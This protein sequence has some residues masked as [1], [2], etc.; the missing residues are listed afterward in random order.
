MVD[1]AEENPNYDAREA[2]HLSDSNEENRSADSDQVDMMQK[3]GPLD[4]DD[5]DN[6]KVGD[7]L[8][9]THDGKVTKEILTVGSG[10]RLNRSYKTWIE[11]KAYFF[12]DHLIFDQS[13]PEP[14][15]LCLGDNSWP[16]G[17]QTGV[18]K[19]RKGEV[20]K[21]RIKKIHGFGRPLR[22]DELRFPKGYEQEGS[23]L[24]NRLTKEQIIYEVRL[25]DFVA[26]KDI[27]ADGNFFK[28]AI[29]EPENHEWE[30]PTD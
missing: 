1:F 7:I 27:E 25:V 10:T 22:V 24:R 23:E 19:M 29:V 11:Y 30:T 17:L 28:Y 18:E 3:L 5:P 16:D 21:I 14:V 4:D 6:D 12:K 26:R 9:I 2:E 15:E 13:G 20:A 8:E